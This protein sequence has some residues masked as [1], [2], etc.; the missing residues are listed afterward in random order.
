MLALVLHAEGQAQPST[1]EPRYTLSAGPRSHAGC[2]TLHLI[3]HA[4]G[5][6]NAAESA[7]EAT[8]THGVLH[9]NAE[10]HAKHGSAWV[11]LEEATSLIYL[12]PPLTGKGEAQA[13]ALRAELHATRASVD[14]VVVS[15]M[16]RTLQTATLGLPQLADELPSATV[17][18]ATEL[19]RERIGPYTCDGR[20]RASQLAAEFPH[21][22]F[23]EVSE[24]DHLWTDGKEHGPA[25]A[26]TLAARAH[27]FAAWVL[28]RPAEHEHIA[29]VSHQHFL[30]AFVSEFGAAGAGDGSAGT[31]GDGALAQSRPF[32]NAERRTLVLC[33]VSG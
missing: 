25:E 17:V 31:C 6:H 24:H 2:K 19:L 20:D 27:R 11:L 16:R 13:A 29:V 21:V 14:A 12:D 5:T 26:A 9:R 33:E 18:I 30:R 10:L 4:E 28:R 23:S 32:A 1:P 8:P 7:E 3:R 15:P 22:D